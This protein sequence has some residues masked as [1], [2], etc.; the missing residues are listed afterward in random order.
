MDA[1]R[2]DL[3]HAVRVLRKSPA[4]TLAAVATLGLGIAANTAIFGFMNALLLR[5]FPLLEADRL[6]SV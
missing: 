1:L 5:P 6:V 2:Q 4:F 3:R